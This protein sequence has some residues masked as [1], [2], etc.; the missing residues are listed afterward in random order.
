MVNMKE[1]EAAPQDRLG[2]QDSLEP[3]MG[4]AMALGIASRSGLLAAMLK[5]LAS[6]KTVEE[7]ASVTR[8]T[9]RRATEEVILSLA[10]G[11]VVK[12]VAATD[13]VP[14]YHIPT[15]RAPVVREM[16][17]IFE[18]LLLH[19]RGLMDPVSTMNLVKFRC[20]KVL[21]GHGSRASTPTKESIWEEPSKRDSAFGMKMVGLIHELQAFVKLQVSKDLGCPASDR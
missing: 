14:R 13:G 3:R 8:A 5:D 15:D 16:G 11:Q 10:G 19:Q 2:N 6:P 17:A 12:E 18:A 9:S 21:Q 4:A 1:G 20:D 7:W